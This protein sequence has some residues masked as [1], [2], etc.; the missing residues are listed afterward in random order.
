MAYESIELE[1]KNGVATLAFNLPQF[2]N[3]LNLLRLQPEGD[4]GRRAR[5]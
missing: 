2:G 5:R 1:V 4:P 3:A